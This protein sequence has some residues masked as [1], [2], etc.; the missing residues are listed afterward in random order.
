MPN[1]LGISAYFHD[2][3]CCLLKDGVLIAASEEERFSRVKHD[4][5]FPK[6]SALYCL[7]EGRLS[8]SDIDC[9]AYYEDPFKKLER[10]VFMMLPHLS[11]ASML[12][13]WM[14]AQR[15]MREIREVLGYT[16]PLKFV[17]HH[18]SHAASSFFFSGFSEAAVM[19]TDGVGE[20]AT[21]TYG[22]A[23][24]K[25][26]DIFEEVHF[27]HSLGLLYSAITSYLGFSVNGDEYKV[28]GL[29]PYGNPT[30]VDQIHEL[31]QLQ[32]GG[33]YCINL[34]YFDFTKKD[35]MFTESLAELLGRPPR[36]TDDEIL[37]FH[38]DIAK[39]LQVVLEDTL[40]AKA[41]YLYERTGS[42]NLCMAGGVALNCVANSR[43]RKEGPFKRLFVQPAAGDAGTCLGA[44]ALA[45]VE[46]TGS[47]PRTNNLEHLFLGPMFSSE[48]VA[49]LFENTSMA[50]QDFSGREAELLAAVVDRLMAGKVIGW[51]QGRMEFGPRALGARSIIA[52][53]RDPTM[54]DRI[55]ML[56]KKRE[57]FRPFAPAVL[58][59]KAH[60]YFDLDRPSPFM[61][62]T[63]Q[64]KTT[65]PLPAI[66]HVDN[67]A[68]VQTVGG[69]TNLRFRKLLEAFEERT[70]C[71]ILLN[72]SF[73]IRN[74][75]IVCT[76]FDA[77]YCFARS[78]IDTLVI[79][80]YVIDRSEL[81]FWE[82]L[83]SSFTVRE[84]RVLESPDPVSQSIYTLL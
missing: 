49:T 20:W 71:P 3:A 38:M 69:H 17:D 40:L 4:S 72:T 21:T 83:A 28:M 37:T 68:R 62:Q 76:P 73:N 64:V 27:P 67:S 16:G 22:H 84:C 7:S 50:P 46:L 12:R 8:I 24:G 32:G 66:T 79:E 82:N 47:C 1:I 59:S 78:G 56:V 42:E 31:L 70:G 45:H 77:L 35:R 74:E 80:D 10:Q 36:Q 6:M 25:E 5:S 23:K 54:R 60:L 13:V 57:S 44:A 75:P 48:Q 26:I 43:I 55:N 53:P 63:Y 61:L 14:N 51:F 58:E 11:E 41:F 65:S 9:I 18:L 81:G 2:S 30:Y 33:Q 34:S 52:D 39:S 19:T 29:A 15:P